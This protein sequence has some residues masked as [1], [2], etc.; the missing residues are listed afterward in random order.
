MTRER[1]IIGVFAD[2]AFAKQG[3]LG[4]DAVASRGRL[5][6]QQRVLSAFLPGKE[7]DLRREFTTDARSRPRELASRAGGSTAKWVASRPVQPPGGRLHREIAHATNSRNARRTT[8]ARVE[9]APKALATLVSAGF[10][11][12]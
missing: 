11:P 8:I 10:D 4:R 3:L 9:L 5:R 12:N 6:L 7:G 2:Q 1:A